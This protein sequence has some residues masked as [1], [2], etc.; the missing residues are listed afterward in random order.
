MRY[1]DVKGAANGQMKSVV[2]SLSWL[3]RIVRPD[4]EPA[5]IFAA[6]LARSTLPVVRR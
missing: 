1:S 6:P 2:G 4:L 5:A 3:A